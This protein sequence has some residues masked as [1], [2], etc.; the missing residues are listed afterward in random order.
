MGL[1]QDESAGQNPNNGM[2]A[3]S[4][5]GRSLYRSAYSS[6][7]TTSRRGVR[8]RG[9]GD[10][11]SGDLPPCGARVS[12]RDCMVGALPE[13]RSS[14]AVAIILDALDR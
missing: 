5:R 14:I 1:E 8:V 13:F 10:R 11:R 6:G 2:V 3:G 7:R 4:R 12:G 9:V